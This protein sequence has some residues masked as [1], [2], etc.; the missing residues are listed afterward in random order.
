MTV[1]LEATSLGFLHFT[2]F[3]HILILVFTEV[4]SFLNFDLYCFEVSELLQ[5]ALQRTSLPDQ[6]CRKLISLFR[7]ESQQLVSETLILT[8]SLASMQSQFLQEAWSLNYNL[9]ELLWGLSW[10][11]L[12]S[13]E[14]YMLLHSFELYSPYQ[15]QQ[16]H[17]LFWQLRLD[18]LG[19]QILFLH[20]A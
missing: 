14:N 13:V 10:H 11:E 8:Y 20:L 15:T 17:V 5:L 16:T 3:E 4:I 7:L 6:P 2:E 1:W 19:H 9:I 18:W 12:V